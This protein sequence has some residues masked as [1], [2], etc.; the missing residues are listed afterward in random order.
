[1]I[2]V[3]DSALIIGGGVNYSDAMSTIAQHL[4]E[5]ATMMTRLGALQVR[6]QGT[7]AGNV[8]NASPIGDTPPVLLALDAILHIDSPA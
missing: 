6:N 3:S 5:F 1:H 2:E 8:A 4:P 7:M